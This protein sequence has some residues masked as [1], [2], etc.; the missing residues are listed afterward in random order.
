MNTVFSFVDREQTAKA[1]T[2]DSTQLALAELYAHIQSMPESA[3]KRKFIKQF[4][5]ENG[6]GTPLMVKQCASS[7]V[8]IRDMFR[9]KIF[10]SSNEKVFSVF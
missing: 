3:K 7:N 5:K 6:Q 2:G 4:N 9:R 1:N 8:G 10:K